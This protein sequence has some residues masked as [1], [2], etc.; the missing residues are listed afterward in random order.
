MQP[1]ICSTFTRNEIKKRRNAGQAYHTKSGKE[2]AERKITRLEKC[3]K[4][5]GLAVTLEDQTRI[6]EA[7]WKPGTYE[8]RFNFLSRLIAIKPKSNCVGKKEKLRKYSVDYHLKTESKD[9]TVCQGCFLKTCGETRGFLRN[10]L[11]KM[12][13]KLNN[14]VVEDD[15]GKIA[16]KNKADSQQ[17][18]EIK[19]HILSFPTHESH[20]S[21][22][23]TSKQYLPP[24][25]NVC[26]MHR[27]YKEKTTNPLSVSTYRRVFDEI[28]L[29]FKVP[30]L[31]TCDKC[32]TLTTQIKYEKDEAIRNQLE[33]ELSAHQLAADEAYEAKRGDKIE[34]AA[35][36][37]KKAVSSFDL[38]K[39]LATPLL[40]TSMA[41]YK[42]QLWT[43]NLTIHSL[44][45][46][47]KCYMWHEAVAKRGGNEIASCILKHLKELPPEIE[48]ITMYS[49]CCPGQNRN[50][51]VAG[52]L[53]AFV[54]DH[55]TL[56]S[57]DHKF[58]VPGHTHMECDSDHAHIEKAKK[59]YNVEIH[60]PADWYDLVKRAKVQEPMQVVVMEDKDFFNFESLFSG[61][62]VMR[63]KNTDKERFY[64]SDVRWLRYTK[65]QGTIQYKTSMSPQAPFYELSIRRKGKASF[66]FQSKLQ[67]SNV[68]LIPISDEKKKDLLDIVHL[69]RPE[70]RDFYVNLP[71]DSATRCIDFDLDNNIS[72][73]EEWVDAQ[74]QCEE[75]SQPRQLPQ[76]CQESAVLGES[77]PIAMK[78]NGRK[79]RRKNNKSQSEDSSL[80]TVESR[81]V[82][83]SKSG[84]RMNKK[85][86]EGNIAATESKHDSFVESKES[87]P[88]SPPRSDKK[89]IRKK[90]EN[91]EYVYYT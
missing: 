84:K 38:Q 31:D 18:E 57:V 61:P 71:S 56:K 62:F 28:G 67:L 88:K 26:H 14:P 51:I 2:R 27:L 30:S 59:K 91:K 75:R 89:R 60:H 29:K 1:V 69:L 43:F 13:D 42:R 79:K 53:A 74:S 50:K 55:P 82:S 6:F 24:G 5:C 87:N 34:A 8:H 39:C 81:L 44:S 46:P 35:S 45:F 85:K 25:L 54:K 48:H 80:G 64:W 83:T 20:Y 63:N 15:R 72:D 36:R 49:D 37:G 33:M 16:P 22:S 40:D 7:Y 86:K 9:V 70:V 17:I 90:K 21:R 3:K 68:G 76:P 78:K 32:N 73:E 47:T 41:F 58:L 11:T 77:I 52:M 23:Q 10:V 66:N 65:D 19:S 4:N 12:F